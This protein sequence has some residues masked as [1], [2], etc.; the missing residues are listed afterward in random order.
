MTDTSSHPLQ[1]LVTKLELHHPL[2]ADDCQAILGLPHKVRNYEAASHLVR[3]GDVP[4]RC[5]VLLS[6]YA[7]RHKVT[8]QGARQIL[9]IHI[10]GEAVDFQ[11]L[12]LSEAD[13]S[14]QMLTRGLVADVPRQAMVDLAT[15]HRNI[16]EAITIA[17]LVEASIF[18]EWTLNIGRRNARERIAHLL[19]EFAV[20]LHRQGFGPDDHYVL[21]M[22]QEQL[23][24]ATGLTP[25]HVNRVLKGLE[26]DGLIERDRR[27][28]RIPHWERMRDIGD[29]NTRYLHFL[30]EHPPTTVS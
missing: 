22:T 19:C 11:N 29:F 17:T 9:S 23:A 15:D 5:G 6:G 13:H 2:G 26:A 27:T 12:F 18:R 4:E 1:L 16:G 20:R 30:H 21:P 14:V 10:P 3:E 7:F 25:V 8:G 24:D 28:I